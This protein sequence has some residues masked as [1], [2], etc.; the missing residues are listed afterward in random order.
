MREPLSGCEREAGLVAVVAL[1]EAESVSL[2]ASPGMA[3]T[4]L[5]FAEDLSESVMHPIEVVEVDVSSLGDSLAMR[6]QHNH[7]FNELLLTGTWIATLKQQKRR[8][9]HAEY[10]VLS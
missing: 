1:G 10:L 3:T 6:M 8:S 7:A 2:R 5:L 4:Y 9:G